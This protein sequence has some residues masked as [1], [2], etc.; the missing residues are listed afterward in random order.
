MARVVFL[1]VFLLSVVCCTAGQPGRCPEC[2]NDPCRSAKCPAVPTAECIVDRCKGCVA[3]FRDGR[4][5]V[6]SLCYGEVPTHPEE[7][8]TDDSICEDD[9]D[10]FDDD[11]DDEDDDGD[12]GGTNMTEPTPS[13]RLSC[14]KLTR[15]CRRALRK[16]PGKICYHSSCKP[17]RRGSTRCER[18]GGKCVNQD[19]FMTCCNS[20]RGIP[21]PTRTRSVC[22]PSPTAVRPN[23]TRSTEKPK[24]TPS[25]RLSCSNLTRFCKKALRKNPGKMCYH[26][27]CKPNRRGSTQCERSGGRCVNQD[28]FMTCCKTRGEPTRPPRPTR[29][30]RPSGLTSTRPTRPPRPTPKPTPTRPTRPTKRL[31]KPTA[32]PPT[33]PRGRPRGRRPS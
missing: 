33:P 12:E 5:D 19:G 16:N 27:T 31:P 28:G 4:R 20:T 1:A 26:S 24:P 15:S 21:T 30:T 17:N 7:P 11:E 25:S 23:P 22:K 14:F 2:S 29:P 32:G 8:T 10:E 6:T 9:D 13:S 3:V 18:R